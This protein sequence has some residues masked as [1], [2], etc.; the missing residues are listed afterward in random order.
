MSLGR[1]PISYGIEDQLQKRHTQALKKALI[2]LDLAGEKLSSDHQSETGKNPIKKTFAAQI[3]WSCNTT[4]Q[5]SASFI[6]EVQ[7]NQE[8]EQNNL[9]GEEE[10]LPLKRQT[11]GC[12]S[13]EQKTVFEA[14]QIS[15]KRAPTIL[16]TSVLMPSQQDP[17]IV[18]QHLPESIVSFPNSQ[19]VT[20][21]RGSLASHK[22]SELVSSK[23]VQ[24]LIE[25]R[26]S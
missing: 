18:I 22:K 2:L 20:W 25:G 14:P 21:R 10:K 5:R 3:I 6:P 24:V 9:A 8:E 16:D 12:F 23:F 4:G 1:A 11:T 7:K 17:K 15:K 26:I 13:R 19:E